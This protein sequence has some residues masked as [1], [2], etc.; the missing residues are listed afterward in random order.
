[1]DRPVDNSRMYSVCRYIDK[2]TL[3]LYA[4]S[5]RQGRYLTLRAMEMSLRK[6]H[7]GPIILFENYSDYD[8]IFVEMLT[9][10]PE[11]VAAIARLMQSDPKI[12]QERGFRGYWNMAPGPDMGD[13]AAKEDPVE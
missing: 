3:E 10:S 9:G 4:G 8:M 13:A 6:Q 7:K 5:E 12:A 11:R 2:K 1:M